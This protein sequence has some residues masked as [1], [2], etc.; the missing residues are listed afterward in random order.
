MKWRVEE[1]DYVVCGVIIVK[2][3]VD[4]IN[5]RNRSDMIGDK[6]FR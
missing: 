3:G 6:W 2:K 5:A 4:L 1:E